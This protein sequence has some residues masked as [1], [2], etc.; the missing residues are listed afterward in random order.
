MD[1]LGISFLTFPNT[2]WK[3][4][5][6]LRK[7]NVL[8]IKAAGIYE[9]VQ[10]DQNQDLAVLILFSYRIRL[11][12]STGDWWALIEVWALLSAILVSFSTF[13]SGFLMLKL[14]T[15]IKKLFY[16]RPNHFSFNLHKKTHE[17]QCNQ[18]SYEIKGYKEIAVYLLMETRSHY[19]AKPF[20]T[21]I[22][23]NQVERHTLKTSN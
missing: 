12:W 14:K 22:W 5:V 4:A 7:K 18:C 16:L 17:H 21:W 6:L 20:P 11:D 19:H 1:K 15:H 13:H 8:C 2:M 3:A 23:R 10:V 9:R